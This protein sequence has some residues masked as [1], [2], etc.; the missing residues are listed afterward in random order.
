[1]IWVHLIHKQNLVDILDYVENEGPSLTHNKF[2][3]FIGTGP[4]RCYVECISWLKRQR[5]LSQKDT[6][7]S[8]SNVY[9]KHQCNNYAILLIKTHSNLVAHE[10][11]PWSFS[12]WKHIQYSKATHQC[13]C[14]SVFTNL[15]WPNLQI[16]QCTCP[17]IHNAPFRTER[18]TFLFWMVHCGISIRCIVGFVGLFY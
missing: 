6:I 7:L 17:I 4:W 1:M 2:G 12:S 10:A 9:L 5:K 11:L 3:C 15:N 14:D 16:P 18:R 13:E 8:D